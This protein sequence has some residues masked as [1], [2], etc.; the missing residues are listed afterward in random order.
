M[1]AVSSVSTALW[2]S[3]R[4]S[5]AF[6]AS[7]AASCSVMSLNT[8]IT[9]GSPPTL[10][11]RALACTQNVSPLRRLSCIRTP[12]A[13]KSRRT[14]SARRWRADGIDVVLEHS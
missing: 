10:M 6:S 1:R 4:L 2:V 7:S 14:I 5:L 13:R 9:D 12:S 8:V 11:R 3:R